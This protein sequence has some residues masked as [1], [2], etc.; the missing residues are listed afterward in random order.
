M[1]IISLRFR[2]G[3]PKCC[4]LLSSCFFRSV[5]K[6]AWKVGFVFSPK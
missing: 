1:D 2:T 4:P 3:F 5:G 6:I